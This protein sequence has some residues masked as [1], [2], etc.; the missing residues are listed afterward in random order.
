MK[1]LIISLVLAMALIGAVFGA[2]ATL[3]VGGV[4][5]LGS[6]TFTVVSPDA[7]TT[8][9]TDLVWTIDSSDISLVSAAVVE[10]TGTADDVGNICVVGLKVFDG[11]DT[12]NGTLD[13][14]IPGTPFT[15]GVLADGQA[16]G[17]L[18]AL[19]ASERRAVRVDLGSDPAEAIRSMAEELA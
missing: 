12:I 11:E 2:A 6:G 14:T 4:D 19:R 1:K 8:S 18:Q 7:G 9:V 10:L 3:N 17:D 13:V 16:V 5:S 15:F